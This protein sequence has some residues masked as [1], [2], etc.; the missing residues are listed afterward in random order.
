MSFP[1]QR[2]FIY[3]E[4][5]TANGTWITYL[6]DGF[7]T[8]SS[9]IVFQTQTVPSASDLANGET[10]LYNDGNNIRWVKK[11]LAGNVSTGLLI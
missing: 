3:R 9:G 6:P 1:Y 8:S 5:A 2:R 11:D 4:Q 10:V 7:R